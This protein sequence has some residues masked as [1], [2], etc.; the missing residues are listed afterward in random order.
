MGTS[1]AAGL[2][3]KAGFTLVPRMT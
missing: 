2:N 1:A 3:H